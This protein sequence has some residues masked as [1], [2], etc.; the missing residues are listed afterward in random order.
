MARLEPG[1]R[2]G[3]WLPPHG[4][5]R[6]H[7]SRLV[8]RRARGVRSS[9]QRGKD[10]RALVLPSRSHL[11]AAA[12]VQGA[13]ASN[14]GLLC[15][16]ARCRPT[17]FG[18]TRPPPIGGTGRSPHCGTPSQARSTAVDVGPGVWSRPY[19]RA[20]RSWRCNR[21]RGGHPP[22][23]RAAGAANQQR[24]EQKR[25]T[26]RLRP[27][28]ARPAAGRSRTPGPARARDKREGETTAF[29][30]S[31]PRGGAGA[32]PRA[33]TAARSGERTPPSAYVCEGGAHSRRQ[34]C[35]SRGVV[36]AGEDQRGSN[37]N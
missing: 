18:H 13:A 1:N 16:I 30:W 21:S 12:P 11:R 10:Q 17:R 19:R 27:A 6:R 14:A 5:S 32:Q 25:D 3:Y 31:F 8:S 7:T 34:S 4:Y 37:R 35:R 29:E 22:C 28:H 2:G 23:H 15:A 33:L 26:S 24:L 36:H 20:H 9:T